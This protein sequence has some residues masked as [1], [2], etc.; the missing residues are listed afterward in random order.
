M[1]CSAMARVVAR[2]PELKAGWPQQD[3]DG[4]STRQPASSRSFTAAKATEGRMRSTRQV[5]KS[6]TRGPGISHVPNDAGHWRNGRTR[7]SKPAE[8]PAVAG[9]DAEE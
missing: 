9:P 7:A 4:T 3:C 5:T 6:P 1:T 8:A 2:S